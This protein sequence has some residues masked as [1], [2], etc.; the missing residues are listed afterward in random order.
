MRSSEDTR[1]L[2]TRF[3]VEEGEPAQVIDAWEPRRVEVCRPDGP[4]PGRE[5]KKRRPESER[6]GG[7]RIRSEPRAVAESQG[8]EAGRGGARVALHHA[9][10]RERRVVDGNPDQRSRNALSAYSM[11]R[12][13]ESPLPE[14]EIQYAD[15]AVWQRAYLAGEVLENEVGYWRETTQGCGGV[16]TADRPPRPADR[17]I[18]E[19]WRG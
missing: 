17:A 18:E 19:A 3:E 16:G 11:A 10:H 13:D 9:S 6:G 2:R 5:R 12:A 4:A 8:I 1:S 14:L 15:F 7:D